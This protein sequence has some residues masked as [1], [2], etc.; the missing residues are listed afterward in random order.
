MKNFIP[1]M[2]QKNISS[3][4]YEKLKKRGIKVLLFDL[5]NTII[6]R[7]NYKL[8]AQTKNLFL[9]LNKDFMIYIISNSFNFEKLE[10]ISKKLNI[11]YIGGSMKPLSKGYKKL[12][13]KSIKNNQIAMIGDQ[14]LT[15]VWGAKRMGY[16]AILTDPIKEEKDMI[17]TKINRFI[18]KLIFNNK[19]NSLERGHYYD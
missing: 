18:E 3:I 10:N 4:N 13:F 8:S 14:L 2:Y 16:M 1:D 15:D 11:S 5:D 19:N 12:K 9:K 7:D 17:L 6:E